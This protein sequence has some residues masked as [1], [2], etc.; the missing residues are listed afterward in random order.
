MKSDSATLKLP[1]DLSREG[2]YLGRATLR[3]MRTGN[4][5][6]IPPARA[7]LSVPSAAGNFTS[8]STDSPLHICVCKG[9][10]A[11]LDAILTS[12]LSP[13]LQGNEE[14]AVW[15]AL[16]CVISATVCCLEKRVRERLFRVILACVCECCVGFNC[17]FHSFFLRRRLKLK[18]SCRFR[19]VR[20]KISTNYH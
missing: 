4:P 5:L 15:T 16:F 12:P 19:S 11:S 8:I 13:N 18:P 10:Q 17:S 2:S 14:G 3:V 6:P 1:R 20:P 9:G 7:P